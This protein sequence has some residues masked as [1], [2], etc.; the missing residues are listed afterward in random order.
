MITP[1][2][3]LRSFV[4]AMLALLAQA[5][6]A[7]LKLNSSRALVVDEATGQ[8]LLEKNSQDIVPMASLTKLLTAMVVLDAQQSPDELITIETSDLDTLKNTR[9]GVPVGK[10]Y[11]REALIERA[12]LTSDNHAA[13]SLARHYPGGLPAFLEAASLKAE[14]LRLTS[15]TIVEPTGL[16]PQNRSS[17]ADLVAVLAAA[18]TY[19]DIARITSQAQIRKQD[20]GRVQ[21]LKNTNHLVGR[22][23]WE[24]LLSKTG[25]TNE[26]GRCVAM[27]LRSAGHTVLVVLLDAPASRGRTLDAVNVHRIV[28]GDTPLLALPTEARTPPANGL[29]KS[30]RRKKVLVRNA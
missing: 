17:A 22:K 28:A 26:A 5:A 20:G 23:G 8:V 14:S 18:A 4:L 6:H 29:T 1:A 11:S 16:S 25:F 30:A 13:S 24:I 27:R 12:L 15:T 2:A 10:S 7:D 21:T 9:G 19:P 3:A